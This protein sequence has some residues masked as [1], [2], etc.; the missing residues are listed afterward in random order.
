[1]K[2]NKKSIFI[3]ILIAVICVSS[4]FILSRVVWGLMA[5]GSSPQIVEDMKS[6]LSKLPSDALI[7]K[8]ASYN[9]PYSF[10]YRSPYPYL[11]LK[12]LVERRE[13][14]AVPLLIGFLK[15]QNIDRRQTAIWA[16]GVINDKRAIKP[17]M[18]IIEKGENN[19]DYSDALLALATMK[20]EGAFPYILERAKKPDA[21][22]NGSIAMLEAYGKSECIPIL[23]DIKSRIKDND[24]MP[25]LGRGLADDAIKNIELQNAQKQ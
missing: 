3:V 22:R 9:R 25:R 12:I 19:S 7:S 4:Y 20:Y 1:M 5:F 16:L 21:Y 17:L 24:P 13:K 15:M 8:L 2:S 23:V 11:S 14:K 18:E 10:F 6:S